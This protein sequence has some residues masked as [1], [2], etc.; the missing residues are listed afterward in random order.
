[1][2]HAASTSG[3]Q[4]IGVAA[5]TILIGAGLLSASGVWWRRI[6]PYNRWV[7]RQILRATSPPAPWSE[8]VVRVS[9]A[10]ML[11]AFG[12][13]SLLAGLVDLVASA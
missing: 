1:L 5:M 4:Y 13:A 9:G 3:T 10:V 7:R 12:L 11:A 6:V 8:K 2:E